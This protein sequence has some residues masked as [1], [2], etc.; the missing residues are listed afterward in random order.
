MQRMLVAIVLVLLVGVA[1][2]GLS[3]SDLSSEV[4]QERLAR[5]RDAREDERRPPEREPDSDRV[6]RLEKKLAD[7]AQVNRRLTRDFGKLKARVSELNRLM[8]IRSTS[9]SGN[10]DS[11]TPVGEPRPQLEV[12]RDEGG[13]F[14]VTD[15]EMAY[16]RAVQAKIDRR[17]RID[18]QTRNYLRRIDSL[19]SRSEIGEIPPEKRAELET[20]LKKFVTLNDDLVTAYVRQPTDAVR[21]LG[22]DE[23]REQ[24]S[25]E[26]Q[27]FS[28]KAKRALEDLLPAEDVGKVSERVF[29]NPW[30]L[31]PRGFNR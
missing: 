16:F 29:T 17:R 24:L 7:S 11:V 20:V 19:V 15:E 2:L 1:Y 22:D 27:K 23:K 25:A 26:R 10:G 30:G 3:L 8:A 12:K 13:N 21:A 5:S 4:E 28:D 31:K 6:L 18:G 9:P 14:V